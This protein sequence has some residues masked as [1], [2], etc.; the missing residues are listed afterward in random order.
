MAESCFQVINISPRCPSYDTL[1][2]SHVHLYICINIQA[3]SK[4]LWLKAKTKWVDFLS[5]CW[6][7]TGLTA[8]LHK[9][10]WQK[11]PKKEGSNYSCD[12]GRPKSSFSI[13]KM[14]TI[15]FG[16]ECFSFLFFTSF[17]PS[18]NNTFKQTRSYHDINPFPQ[19]K[20]WLAMKN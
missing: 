19:L 13:A 12:F 7:G 2:K 4:E 3:R 17:D 11:K 16:D 8:K 10:Q 1:Y 5:T 6:F 14:M 20:W 9:Q 15:I 18:G